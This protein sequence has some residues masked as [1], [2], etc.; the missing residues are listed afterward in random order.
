MQLRVVRDSNRHAA[1]KRDR[2]KN[3]GPL[4]ALELIRAALVFLFVGNVAMPIV[5][6]VALKLMGRNRVLGMV[7][8][9]RHRTLIAMVNVVV[10]VDMA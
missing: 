7:A 1:M 10:I 6:L 9:I 4:R 3:E 2:I 8:A 5:Y